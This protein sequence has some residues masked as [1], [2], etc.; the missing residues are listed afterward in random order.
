MGA[1]AGTQPLIPDP[2]SSQTNLQA[3]SV[4]RTELYK[5]LKAFESVLVSLDE[6]RDLKT[7]LS[8]CEKKLA[9]SAMELGK[10]KAI[11]EVPSQTLM[12]AC[13]IFDSVQE[14]ASKHAKLAQKEYESLN[15]HCAKFFK[16]VAKEER[17]YDEQLE[18]LESKVKKA[19]AS[20]EKMAKKGMRGTYAV[21][22][23][24][25]YIN[26]VQALT[27]DIQKLK[28]A[29]S[30]SVGTKTYVASLLT[31][32]TLGGLADAE[33]KTQC[34]RVR[35]AG[36]HIGKLNEWLNFA[37]SEA[38]ANVKP[39]DLNEEAMGWAQVL[40]A[41]EAEVREEQRR[42]DEARLAELERLHAEWKAHADNVATAAKEEEG[43]RDKA[44]AETASSNSANDKPTSISLASLPRLDS[45]GRVITDPA[46]TQSSKK[47]GIAASAADA[48]S[49][50]DTS[51]DKA[52]DLI[53]TEKENAESG[54]TAPAPAEQ[55]KGAFRTTT[56]ATFRSIKHKS[57]TMKEEQEKHL[58]RVSSADEG[59]VI[60]RDA[61]DESND[62]ETEV[63]NAKP[64]EAN[65]PCDNAESVSDATPRLVASAPTS[66]ASDDS[67]ALSRT[68]SR[69]PGPLTP[70]DDE[71][72]A[73][74]AIRESKQ[75][76]PF[77]HGLESHSEERHTDSVLRE[78]VNEKYVEHKKADRYVDRSIAGEIGEMTKAEPL[79]TRSPVSTDEYNRRNTYSRERSLWERE[80]ERQRQ[81]EREEEL[82]RRL[83]HAEARLR[84]ADENTAFQTEAYDQRVRVYG[85]SQPNQIRS[86]HSEPARPSGSALPQPQHTFETSRRRYDGSQNYE[87][88]VGNSRVSAQGVTRT[89]STD[90][91]RSFVARMRERYQ[92]EKQDVASLPRPHRTEYRASSN[93][94]HDYASA[95]MPRHIDVANARSRHDSEPA[96]GYRQTNSDGTDGYATQAL[97]PQQT[98]EPRSSQT[99][100]TKDIGYMPPPQPPHAPSCGCWNCSARHYRTAE[101]GQSSTSGASIGMTKSR[102]TGAPPAPPPRHPTATATTAASVGSGGQSKSHKAPPNNRRQSMPVDYH[103]SSSSPSLSTEPNLHPPTMSR[104]FETREEEYGRRSVNERQPPLRTPR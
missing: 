71:G 31:A 100:P 30:A 81:T 89:L 5:G 88:T 53:D 23:H 26:S 82:E 103:P 91:E 93:V 44:P 61:G 92:A 3:H 52:R 68:N 66:K 39:P 10:A 1:Q 11:E 90:S 37:T 56:Q 75:P 33:F 102:P 45:E 16:R 43:R 8:K 83:A 63:S 46:P 84:K 15:E 12:A 99:R 58:R 34:E 76:L 62:R 98:Q 70:R 55:K 27:A 21:E 13:D 2:A 17:A 69:S 73:P 18:A 95:S 65:K 85:E 29:H 36:P 4:E 86:R 38:M 59:T 87:P 32:S 101:H 20:H 14:V 97:S 74:V 35:K 94:A 50:T 47:A 77:S 42:T 96:K 64:T 104:S 49:A 41:K 40:A 79:R 19:H 51:S 24:D 78:H 80:R 22:A 60:I 25:K 54:P 48:D 72:D 6:H 67:R 9:K 28:T 7:R 57:G